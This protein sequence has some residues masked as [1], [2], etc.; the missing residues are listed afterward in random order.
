MKLKKILLPSLIIL[1]IIF[2]FGTYLLL[3]QNSFTRSVKDI[4][5]NNFKY[6]LKETVFIIPN[7]KKENKIL[8][9]K[10]ELLEKDFTK[11]KI[12]SLINNEKFLGYGTNPI[13]AKDENQKFIFEVRKFQLASE[14]HNWKGYKNVDFYK[15]RYLEKFENDLIILDYFKFY[16]TKIENLEN[17]D[18]DLEEIQTNISK[19]KNIIGIRDLKIINNTIF[20]SAVTIDKAGCN[21]LD[22][23]YS[24]VNL[25][26]LEFKKLFSTNFELCLE[27]GMQS[28]GRL[29]EYDNDN[30]LVS[31]GDFGFVKL[32]MDNDYMFND[33]NHI[34]KILKV[35]KIDGKTKVI[36][37]GHRNPQGLIK[38][39]KP[40]IIISTEHGPKGGDEINLNKLDKIYNF[41]WPVASYGVLYSGENPFVNNH[42][43]F[44][45]E[46]PKR[47][48][49][50]SIAIGQIIEKNNVQK[51]FLFT[52]LR[53]AS[54]Y[55]IKFDENYD[56][57]LFEKK[58]LFGER[59]RDILKINND[60]FAVTLDSSPSI[61]LFYLK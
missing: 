54:V 38:L 55:H 43:D 36:S 17:E 61:G 29:D 11:F 10:Y 5:P 15:G 30:L 35:N 56:D 4:F 13:M 14:P 31:V 48:Y 21:N 44:N 42:K 8:K 22:I 1:L 32:K 58:Y 39:N 23:L 59:I 12:T 34:G 9:E 40:E 46:E 45:F 52:S 20:V 2:I 24:K 50:P 57:I 18:L 3:I 51:E 47:Y 26:N 16:K 53:S 6:F 49:V 33:K 27:G 60:Y 37:K 7:L 28:G 19:F 25:N 41:G